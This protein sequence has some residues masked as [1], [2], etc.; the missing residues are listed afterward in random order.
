M[1][2]RL[3]LFAPSLR[4]GGAERVMVTLACEFAAKGYL[5]DLVLAKAEGPYL[6]EIPKTV[7]LIDLKAT[8]VFFSLF[9]LVRYLRKEKPVALLSSVINANVI[10]VAAKKISNVSTR[11]ILR[12]SNTLSANVG[13]HKGISEKI[14]PFMARL[15]YPLSDQVIA[16]SNGVATDLM[17]EIGL[18]EN[19]LTVIYS[20]VV[21]SFMFRKSDEELDH[22]WFKK[23]QPP[24]VL[25]VGRL[26]RQKGFDVLIQAVIKARETTPIRLIILGEGS[27]RNKLKKIIEENNLE[28]EIS[29]PGFITNPFPY[30]KNA[31]VFVLSSRWEGLPNVL[32]QAMVLGTA[33]ISTNCPSGP[34][35]ILESGKWGDIVNVDDVIGLAES[36]CKVIA[37]GSRVN[38]EITKN[39]C[40]QKFG[41]NVVS[42][43]YLSKML[44]KVVE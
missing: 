12:E 28:N 37:Q 2:Q 10:A 18:P 43:E 41:M 26:S 33:V 5:V 39:Y 4:G 42:N 25:G 44:D 20:P 6:D 9:G 23:N 21:S 36:I 13:K 40:E 22:P 38:C 34:D 19:K 14:M 35:E 7:N 32:I 30:M 17:T 1:K 8:R 3:A 16:V 11:V 31:A 27:D 24:V 29:L 15:F